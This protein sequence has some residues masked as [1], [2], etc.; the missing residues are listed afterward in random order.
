MMATSHSHHII[1]PE[2][3]LDVKATTESNNDTDIE[4]YKD[5]PNENRQFQI[6]DDRQGETITKNI[7]IKIYNNQKIN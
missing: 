5:H 2:A 7:H 4:L 1:G 6:T 3:V